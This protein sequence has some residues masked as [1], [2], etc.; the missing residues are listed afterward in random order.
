MKY[1]KKIDIYLPNE[2]IRYIIDYLWIC[3]N[4][5]NK[6]LTIHKDWIYSK[7][8]VCI[9]CYERYMYKQIVLYSHK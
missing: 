7:K 4:C 3:N 9:D 6:F 2:I 1:L 8:T 5:K